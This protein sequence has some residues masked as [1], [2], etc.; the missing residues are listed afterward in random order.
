[1]NAPKD[2]SAAGQE[3]Q[4]VEPVPEQG[5]GSFFVEPSVESGLLAGESLSTGGFG[6]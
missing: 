2:Y 5:V 6:R 1:M 4:A 3:S